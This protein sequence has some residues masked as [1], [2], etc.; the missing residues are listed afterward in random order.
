MM[1]KRCFTLI[2][3]LVV[4]AIIAILA[5]MLLPALQQARDRAHST[6]CINNLKQC[7]V[8]ASTYFDDH[9]NWWVASS[10]G[11][12]PTTTIDDITVRTNT[13]L[14]NFYTGKYIKDTTALT[15]SGPTQYF[16]PKMPLYPNR[17]DIGN[18][19]QVYG[20]VYIHNPA[21]HKDYGS[22]NGGFTG[23]N[24]MAPSLS[25]GYA[26]ANASGTTVFNESLSP[27]Q[28]I[29][30]FDCTTD[31]A[32]GAMSS[33]GFVDETHNTGYSKPY[34]LH[35][36]RVNMLAVGANVASADESDFLDSY[37]FP[38][39]GL[40]TPRSIRP[41]GYYIAPGADGHQYYK[42]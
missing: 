5:A 28:R 31:V 27:S 35:S 37:W 7:G 14:Y 12:A 26:R 32:G 11:T 10:N 17:G 38:F 16:C 42:H 23:Y 18:Y 39:F 15:S 30:L 22:P 1:K 2:E 25:K 34:L 9:N 13:Y 4:I 24:V 20:T 36:G 19:S 3:L 8:V 41:Q 33:Q 40:S 21:V 6:R 29:L